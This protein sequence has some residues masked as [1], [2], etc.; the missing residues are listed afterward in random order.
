M[1]LFDLD[2]W[3]EIWTTVS[4][5]RLRAFLTACG[6]F[7]G[8]FM[9]VVLLGVGNGLERGTRKNLGNMSVRSVFVW[10][11]RTSLPFRG[12]QPGRY[13]RMR[14]ADIEAVQQVKGVRYVSP[15]LQLGGWRDG[16]NVTAGSKGGSFTVTGDYPEFRFVEPFRIT[17]GRFLNAPDM[18]ERRKVCVL[19]DQ[20]SSVLFGTDDPVGR[21]VQVRGVYLLVVG[22]LISEKSG[23]DADRVR[24]SVFV[25]FSTFQRVFNERDRVGWFGLTAFDD[26]APEQVEASVKRVLAERH[27]VHP[28]DVDALGSFNA[29]TQLGK[30]DR[31]FRGL[32]LFV[33]FVGTLTLFA[34]VLGVSNILL[35][36]VKERTREL[37]VR[38]ALG[39][40]PWS[41]IAMIV[42]EA[43]VLTS[44]SGYLGLVASVG[45]LELLSSW[46]DRVPNAPLNHPE[47]DLRVAGGATLIL[48]LSGA[49][50]GVFPA[51]HAARISPVEALRTE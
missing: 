11:Q 35:I 34:G 25:P 1:G 38:K 47:I 27:G 37:G 21:Y 40:T 18:S 41:I 39:A 51:R 20:V 33:W 31:L 46:L 45:A 17:R 16:Q 23:D 5:N 26:A 32:A 9:L 42:K 43:V 29:A 14:N 48:V 4:R 28:N 36:T 8:I 19:G 12:R 24:S 7:W 15:R 50:A 3:Q 30:L 6:V 10:T 44:L 2:S 49:L 13:L 22:E